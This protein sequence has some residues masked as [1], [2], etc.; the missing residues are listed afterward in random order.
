MRIKQTKS[1]LPRKAPDMMFIPANAPPLTPDNGGA[2]HIKYF[3]TIREAA[4]RNS[5]AL[6]YC[7][8]ATVYDVVRAVADNYGDKMSGE[9]FSMKDVSELRDD[10]M[11]TLGE[12]IVPLGAAAET[13][14]E[15]G[16]TVSMFPIFPGGG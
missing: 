9:L 2:I 14:V 11:L 7:P 15:P 5:D 3:G 1:G 4:G 16:D 10:L 8:G 12:A 6:E 13:A